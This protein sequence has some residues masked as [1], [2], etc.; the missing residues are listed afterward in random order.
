M[1]D[2]QVPEGWTLDTAPAVRSLTGPEGDLRIDFL[3]IPATG[4]VAEIAL[5]AW[6]TIAPLF[7]S[8]ILREVS[9]S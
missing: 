4:S 1:P 3:E 8:K 2:F 6:K 7:D 9:M 5:S